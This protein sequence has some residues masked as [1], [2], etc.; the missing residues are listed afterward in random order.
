VREVIGAK[1]K[2]VPQVGENQAVSFA[3]L[4]TDGKDLFVTGSGYIWRVTPMGKIAHIA[5]AGSP[6]QF[7]KGYDAMGEN[8]AKK[9]FLRYRV[10]DQSVMGAT[11]A[12]A[13]HGG[14]LY[15][16]GKASGTYV[17]KI[18]CN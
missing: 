11:A 10:G 6:L 17:V 12:I 9:I 7:P 1:G 14:A 13:H 18:D 16:R 8:P 4:T 15:Y 5:G 3:G 2:D